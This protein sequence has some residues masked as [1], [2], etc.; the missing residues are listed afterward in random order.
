[1]EMKIRGKKPTRRQ[2]MAIAAAN[3]NPNNWLVQSFTVDKLIIQHKDSGKIR[4]IHCG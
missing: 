2:K 1:M 4:T 3:L